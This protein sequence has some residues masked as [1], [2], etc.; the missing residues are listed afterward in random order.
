MPDYPNYTDPDLVKLLNGG[1]EKAFTEIYNRYWDKLFTTAVNRL[2]EVQ[3]AR[4]IVQNIFFKLWKRRTKVEIAQTLSVYLAAA[5]KYEVLNLLAAK[6]RHRIY[7]NHIQHVQSDISDETLQQLS[8]SELRK[9]LESIVKDLPEK[10]RLVYKLSREA[11]Y[12]NN[13][14]ARVMHISEK[15]VEAHLSKALRRLR[16]S[17]GFFIHFL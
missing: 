1:D 2:G 13:E 4:E 8:F 14:I 6:N 16:N 3:E 9:E 7:Q 17:L 10:C 15:T 12:T 5:V 11:G